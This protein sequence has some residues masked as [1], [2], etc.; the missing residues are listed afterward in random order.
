MVYIL[1]VFLKFLS[2]LKNLK[3][4]L[5]FKGNNGANA[6]SS[7]AKYKGAVFNH[8]ESFQLGLQLQ[9]KMC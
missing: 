3:N 7:Y 4:H 6:Q 9:A 1:S 5:F 2:V 8:A